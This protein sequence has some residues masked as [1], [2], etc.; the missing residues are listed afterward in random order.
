MAQ[1]FLFISLVVIVVLSITI[2]LSEQAA[3]IALANE[4]EIDQA[5]SRQILEATIKIRMI[6]PA[7]SGNSQFAGDTAD[8]SQDGNLFGSSLG[9][10]AKIG[11]ETVIVT[12]DHWS[13][14]S[15]P[16]TVIL[17]S[18]AA[19][20]MNLVIGRNE[21]MDLIRYRDGGT[22][23]VDAPAHLI[24][25]STLAPELTA[26]SE[27]GARPGDIMYVVRRQLELNDALTVEPMVLK[28]IDKS[29]VPSSITLQSI[30]GIVVGP[31]N[32][33]G[34]V[35]H[36][37]QLIANIWSAVLVLGS[38]SEAGDYLPT[39]LSQAALLPVFPSR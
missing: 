33:G 16:Q 21:F 1:K 25:G 23:I 18:R 26:E 31:G 38:G 22:M 24:S 6:S 10:L 36:D 3:G 15:D 30:N 7:E 20:G 13:L 29:E 2:V 9:T 35:W 8:S 11:G 17:I 5:I 39:N 12:H 19:D 4:A 32:S 28:S 37:G 34:G 27:P 14:L